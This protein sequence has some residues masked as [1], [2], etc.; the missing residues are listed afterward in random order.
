MSKR[1]SEVRL[2]IFQKKLTLWSGAYRGKWTTVK[3]TK[4]DG[5]VRFK[6]NSKR[7]QRFKRL[8]TDVSNVGVYSKT[9]DW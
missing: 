7:E 6:K 8:L 2:S 5:I 1:I 9:V 3:R 4:I